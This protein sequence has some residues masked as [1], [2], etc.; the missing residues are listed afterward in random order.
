MDVRGI[1]QFAISILK[2]AKS[3]EEAL[4]AIIGQVGKAVGGGTATELNAALESGIKSRRAAGQT[5]H[6]AGKFKPPV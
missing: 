5:M 3:N 6:E 4:R 2:S 1:A